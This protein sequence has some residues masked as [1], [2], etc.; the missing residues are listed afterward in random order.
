MSRLSLL[1][2]LVLV[3]ASSLSV[4]ALPLPDRSSVL[5]PAGVLHRLQSLKHASASAQAAPPVKDNVELKVTVS[6]NQVKATFAQLGLT[7]LKNE[8]RDVYFYD[9]PSLEL[10]AAGM[11]LRSRKVYNGDDDSTIKLRPMSRTAVAASWFKE[12]GFK[13]EVDAVGDKAVESCS[14]S[15]MQKRGEIDQVVAKKRLIEQLYSAKQ[16]AFLKTSGKPVDWT[17]LTTLG[18]VHSQVWAFNSPE[19][20]AL[21]S[22]VTAEAWTLPNGQVMLELSIKVPR[23]DWAK[24]RARFDQYLAA[25]RVNASNKQETKTKVALNTFVAMLKK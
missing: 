9:T 5:Q 18:P 19:S 21:G 1:C 15:V 6:A 11:V 12:S 20:F 7:S 22:P 4:S 10:S 16:E 25:I 13:C 23:A 24:A 14:L 17:K 3:C 2:A 8:K